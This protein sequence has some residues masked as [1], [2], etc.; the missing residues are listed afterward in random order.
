MGNSIIVACPLC[1]AL[2]KAG[3][4]CEFCGATIPQPSGN[5]NAIQ[6]DTRII[7]EKQTVPAE[8]FASKIS[9]Y[10]RVEPWK[11][12]LAVV[13]IGDLHGAINRNGD[14]VIPLNYQKVKIQSDPFIILDN[15]VCY[16]YDIEKQQIYNLGK[17]RIDMVHS[18]LKGQIIITYVT[19]YREDCITGS[20]LP[21]NYLDCVID[22]GTNTN[23]RVE[24]ES[25]TSINKV[26]PDFNCYWSFP[27]QFVSKDGIIKR[28]KG[29]AKYKDNN[30]I[31]ETPKREIT[32]SPSEDLFAA[33]GSANEQY[34][35][36]IAAKQM[37]SSA[38]NQQNKGCAVLLLPLLAL[39][40]G[41]SFGVIEL[42][43]LVLL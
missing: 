17:R 26:L 9:K 3:E 34:D 24:L 27:A 31:L 8:E 39:G 25:A 15:D 11:H 43:K 14:I 30:L 29:N 6:K 40:A 32:I 5:T 18:G 28:F 38:H 16:V 4:L 35:K 19:K 41:A 42:I 33:I 21:D 2:G 20:R 12:N 36:D 10:H 23:T 22:I 1:G 7:V 13:S 37:E